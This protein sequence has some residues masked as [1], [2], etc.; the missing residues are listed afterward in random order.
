MEVTIAKK[1]GAKMK[2]MLEYFFL[3]WMKESLVIF[4]RRE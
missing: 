4:W 1:R 3:K 2:K